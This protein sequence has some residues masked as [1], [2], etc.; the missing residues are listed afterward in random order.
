VQPAP[1]AHAETRIEPVRRVSPLRLR[2]GSILGLDI[3][4]PD[5]PQ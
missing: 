1:P 5:D 2:S 3:S 4:R